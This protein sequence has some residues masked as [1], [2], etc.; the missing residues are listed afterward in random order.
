MCVHCVCMCAHECMNIC[1]YAHVWMSM[2]LSVNVHVSVSV[3]VMYVHVY[4][5]VYMC[6]TGCVFICTSQ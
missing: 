4:V 5:R 2:C 1:E 3:Y 6:G